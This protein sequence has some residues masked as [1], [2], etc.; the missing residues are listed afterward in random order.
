MADD[1]RSLAAASSRDTPRYD[2]HEADPAR[3]QHVRESHLVRQR[4][5]FNRSAGSC[6]RTRSG[7]MELPEELWKNERHARPHLWRHQSDN[8]A[9]EHYCRQRELHLD[10]GSRGHSTGEPDHCDGE[11][12]ARRVGRGR[13]RQNQ[14]AQRPSCRSTGR[15]R[16]SVRVHCLDNSGRAH[17]N[18]RGICKGGGAGW[19]IH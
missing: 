10:V 11:S 1:G 2:H 8:A 5:C 18:S 19:Q 17:R 12:E 6:R 16:R 15:S 14:G 9:R 13:G 3:S 4:T 7:S